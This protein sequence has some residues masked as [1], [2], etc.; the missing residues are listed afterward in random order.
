M[1]LWHAQWHVGCV[2]H[3]GGTM[4]CC[5]TGRYITVFI[6]LHY[7]E[8]QISNIMLSS[9]FEI[10]DWIFECPMSNLQYPANF[11]DP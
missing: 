9:V 5:L 6:C 8:Y 10:G 7:N 4:I 11:S 1:R 3:N 2:E